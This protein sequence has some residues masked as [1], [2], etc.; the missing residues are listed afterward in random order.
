MNTPV[1]D[2]PSRYGAVAMTLH[3]LIAA[4]IILNIIV[5]LTA[6][7]GRTPLHMAMMSFH[8]ALG[9]TV[10]VLS[11]LRLVWRWLNPAPPPPQGLAPWMR[12]AGAATHHTLYFLMIAIPLAGWLMVSVNHFTPSWFGLFAWPAIPGFG[13]LDKAASHGWH[14]TFETIHV[15]LGW[16][17]II[18]IPAHI[19]AGLYHH[20]L[21]KDNVLLRML[22]GTRLR[23]GV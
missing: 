17:M 19:V 2:L 8:M 12:I 16:A 1:H 7:E 21:R 18:L 10:L 15:V 4:A 3:W 9:L 11:I 6:P 5:V 20:V 13:G 14:E 23:S 22:P